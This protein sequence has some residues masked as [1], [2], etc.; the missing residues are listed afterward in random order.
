MSI[1][2]NSILQFQ[3]LVCRILAAWRDGKRKPVVTDI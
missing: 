3:N 2:Y 1:P